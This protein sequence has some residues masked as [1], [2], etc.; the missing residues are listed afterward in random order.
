[1]RSIQSE[2]ESIIKNG[3]YILVERP[4]HATIL[5]CRYV[6]KRKRNSSNQ[7]ICFKVRFCAKEFNQRAGIDYY[8][9]YDAGAKMQS[10]CVLLS[11]SVQKKWKI[12]QVDIYTAFLNGN[13]DKDIY[14]EQP[15][16]FQIKDTNTWFAS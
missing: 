7:L 13:M 8:E 15:E 12:Q 4:N 16:G 5:S 9:T 10:L 14:I 3:M 11:V 1:M 2:Y 6:L